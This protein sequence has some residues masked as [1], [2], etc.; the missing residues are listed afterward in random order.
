MPGSPLNVELILYEQIL[1]K[2][3]KNVEKKEKIF[4][5]LYELRQ[6]QAKEKYERNYIHNKGNKEKVKKYIFKIFDIDNNF[7]TDNDL[8]KLKKIFEEKSE[9]LTKTENG[10]IYILNFNYNILIN[11]FI[12]KIM[13]RNIETN[14]N[15]FNF[16]NYIN[17][18]EDLNNKF[19]DFLAKK[20][21]AA[22]PS[23]AA[24]K[25]KS[26]VLGL[27]TA[28][29]SAKSPVLG[30]PAAVKKEA[31]VPPASPPAEVLQLEQL[32]SA[33]D[34]INSYGLLE[35]FN[36][37]ID[38]NPQGL[39]SIPNA[40][41]EYGIYTM[42]LEIIIT[43]LINIYEEQSKIYIQKWSK[44]DIM[45][46]IYNN[47][48]KPENDKMKENENFLKDFNYYEIDYNI[49]KK[50]SDFIIIK[51]TDNI[52]SYDKYFNMFRHYMSITYILYELNN[53]EAA[54]FKLLFN[55]IFNNDDY[56]DDNYDI[57]YNNIR[58]K[59][60]LIINEINYNKV[61]GYFNITNLNN[62]F[63]NKYNDK[64]IFKI[65][66]I[67]YKNIKLNNIITAKNIH[68]IFTEKEKLSITINYINFFVDYNEYENEE[69]LFNI[70]TKQ[71]DR[72]KVEEVRNEVKEA[73]IIINEKE[74][75]RKTKISDAE[76]KILEAKAII[77][78]AREDNNEEKIAA[79]E[80]AAAADVA[81]EE[82]KKE[83]EELKEASNMF[84][85]KKKF[86]TDL[87]NLYTGGAVKPVKPAKAVKPTKAKA[88][89]VTKPAKAKPAKPAKAAKVAKP[90]KP[91][92]P[93]KAK[94]AKVT[95]PAKAAKA[96]KPT[97]AKVTKPAKAKIAKA[98]AILSLRLL[99]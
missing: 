98:R 58:Q 18:K 42:K 40:I 4:V 84:N 96:V 37:T 77:L 74:R 12:E 71:I 3:I 68:E 75:N 20:E 29:P 33:K 60:D 39:I 17:L 36:I 22:K 25:E 80:A 85:K 30:L 52:L 10:M 31:K 87:I 79:A 82:A 41:F 65:I 23:A 5:K 48:I 63:K 28:P 88:A 45:T 62:M 55:Q 67:T 47:C 26:P 15:K 19:I 94:P 8:K 54:Y 92:K 83:I 14:I 90:A 70:F 69:K 7:E 76:A 21:A 86:F 73:S 50:V 27:P 66:M 43:K 6:I 95:K 91:A 89:K 44:N 24:K 64:E 1:Q 11:F 16:V 81:L 99:K 38:D 97:K 56:D 32:P 61:N 49:E 13:E 35:A 46:N 34:Q 51:Y 93:T 57:L 2:L 72:K 59:I 9:L 78:E 53:N